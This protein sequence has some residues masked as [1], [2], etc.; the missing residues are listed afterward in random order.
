MGPLGAL[1]LLAR[2]TSGANGEGDWVL[3]AAIATHSARVAVVSGMR[4]D[5]RLLC[6]E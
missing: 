2:E 4:R 6:V 1:P 3:Q 5:I